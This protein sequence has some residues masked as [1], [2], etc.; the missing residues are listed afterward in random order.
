MRRFPLALALGLLAVLGA[1]GDE[2]VGEALELRSVVLV[3]ERATA[4]SFAGRLQLDV[5]CE[6]LIDGNAN[7]GPYAELTRARLRARD[8]VEAEG[9]A[10]GLN[11][12]RHG[13]FE[14][15]FGLRGDCSAGSEVRGQRRAELIER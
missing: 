9:T 12:P 10:R 4:G 11:Q 14:L 7:V 1:C 13:R 15:I 2:M 6:Q 8:D 5:P 3:S